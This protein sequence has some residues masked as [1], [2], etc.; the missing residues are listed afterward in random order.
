MS[1]EPLDEHE[2][3]GLMVAVFSV[4]AGL[5]GVCLT[6]I[7]LLQVVT[8][9]NKV[10]T[11]GEELLAVDALFFLATCMLAFFSFRLK[12]GRRKQ[13]VRQLADSAFL[14][15]LVLMSAVAALIAFAV[16]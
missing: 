8:N 10:S 7:G 13:Q 9:L 12:E 11:L 2:E 1:K 14:L 6:G 4:S 5:I 16:F 3:H 15:G